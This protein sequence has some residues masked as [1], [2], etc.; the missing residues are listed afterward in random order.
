MSQDGK[1]PSCVGRGKQN[2]RLPILV[3]GKEDCRHI[4]KGVAVQSLQTKKGCCCK[5]D[6][7]SYNDVFCHY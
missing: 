6:C 3:Q 5:R 7:A 2:P 1:N 4:K